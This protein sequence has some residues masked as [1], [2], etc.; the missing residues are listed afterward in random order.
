M[1]FLAH[2]GYSSRFPGNTLPA[3]QAV[4]EHPENGRALKGIELDIQLTGDNRIAVLHDTVIPAENGLSMPVAA[5]SLSRLRA[6]L[7]NRHCGQAVETPELAQVLELVSHRTGLC[8]EIKRADYHLD[9]LATRLVTLLE[10]YKPRGDITISSFSP[11]I[12]R[13]LIPK[14]RHLGIEYAFIF[15]RWEAIDTVPESTRKSL[16]YIHP[17]YRLLLA[18]PHR[19]AAIGIRAQCWTVNDAESVQSLLALQEARHIDAVMTDDIGLCEQS[20]R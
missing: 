18:A 20:A 2:R 3:F 13:A 1:N 5:L 14:T 9:T 8:L 17:D 10:A 15:D 7:R 4:L 16:G 11:A 19:L 6:L 12:L